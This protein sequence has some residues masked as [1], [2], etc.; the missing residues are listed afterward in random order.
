M[1]RWPGVGTSQAVQGEV[2]PGQADWE[3]TSRDMTPGGQRMAGSVHAAQGL[4]TPLGSPR[5]SG[6]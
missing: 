4:E 2:R 3:T 1:E 5:D 6:C